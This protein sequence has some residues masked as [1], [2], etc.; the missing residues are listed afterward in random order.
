MNIGLSGSSESATLCYD[1]LNNSCARTVYPLPFRLSLYFLFTTI[2]IL[3]V[4]GN[5]LVT[6]VLL[7]SQNPLLAA[8]NHLILS[9]SVAG[10]LI[11]GFVMP[12]SMVRS[13]ETCWYFGQTF[14]EIHTTVDVVLCNASMWHLTFISV[15]RYIAIFYPLHYRN[16][17]TK[18]TG[19]AMISS[20]WGLGLVFGFA[21]VISDPEVKI[22]DE[23][24][25]F[26]VGGCFSLHA[27]EI[28]VEYSIIFY[29]IPVCIIITAYGRIFFLAQRHS[30]VTHTY[31][32]GPTISASLSA[33]GL[34]T[35][36]TLAIVVGTFL[37]CW[38]PFFLCNIIDPIIG[39]SIN[40]LL[41][42]S[43]MWVAYLNAMFSPLIYAFFYSWFRK[44]AKV[45]L[46]K[47]FMRM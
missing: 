46:S 32:K 37:F 29:F 35:T 13:I 25:K 2:V 7:F 22:R 28:G 39:H 31:N 21:I 20:S 10:F 11:G 30:K 45:L 5:M 12:H 42:E 17:M 16:L 3:T 26:C 43:L 18:T 9:L 33:K 41:Y 24:Y 23:Y 8:T 36:K 27:R 40:T 38:T 4:S 14:C 15:D 47:L 6:F 19:V 44:T 1:T 34:K